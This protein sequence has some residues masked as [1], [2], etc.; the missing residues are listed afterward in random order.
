MTKFKTI[1]HKR[2]K[3]QR[4]IFST[5]IDRL[6]IVIIAFI[7][8]SVCGW[9]TPCVTWGSRS[10]TYKAVCWQAPRPFLRSSCLQPA[11]YRRNMFLCHGS[12]L[13]ASLPLTLLSPGWKVG[14]HFLLVQIF[15]WKYCFSAFRVLYLQERKKISYGQISILVGRVETLRCLKFWDMMVKC[16][17]KEQFFRL[18]KYFDVVTMP[19]V[20]DFEV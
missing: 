14:F 19:H 12:I 5:Y 18:S 4:N 13:T 6:W 7:N 10:M 16:R 15:W 17:Q 9:T 11:A 3:I 20:W 8:R 2:E 1:I